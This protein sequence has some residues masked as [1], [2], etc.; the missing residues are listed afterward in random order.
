MAAPSVQ[1]CG[2]RQAIGS[3]AMAS[4]ALTVWGGARGSPR[5]VASVACVACVAWVASVA[6]A[7]SHAWIPG[8]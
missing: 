6:D 1:F 7:W 4:L 3:I 8:S 2:Y 5:S